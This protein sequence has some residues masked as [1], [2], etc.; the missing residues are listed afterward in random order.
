MAKFL[1]FLRRSVISSIVGYAKDFNAILKSIELP[2]LYAS[3]AYLVYTDTFNRMELGHLQER[4]NPF[5]DKLAEYVKARGRSFQAVNLGA[6]SYLN[7]NVAAEREAASLL[8]A[9]FVRYASEFSKNSYSGATGMINSFIQ[10]MKQKN[11]A[12]AI[13]T[14]K[15]E[16]KVK[17]LL[18]EDA[19]CESTH[20]QAIVTEL[21]SEENVTASSIRGE[22]IK[23]ASN[24]MVFIG[25]RASEEK[26][27]KWV[28]LNG[29]IA[30]HNAK[31]E[32][33]EAV[34][35][36]ALKKK[37]EEKKNDQKPKA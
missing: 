37:R 28:E 19:L 32:K 6:K 12:G 26:G 27:S 18:D 15:M 1:S 2:E 20:L 25:I 23:A 34:R 4:K 8:N 29:Q 10:D 11:Y 14:L 9:L 7:S 13:A 35:Q 33:A 24:L 3:N 22:F 31:F 21:E 16:A 30:I 17:Q 5:T 36:A